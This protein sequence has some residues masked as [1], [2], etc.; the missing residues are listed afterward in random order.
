MGAFIAR[1][2][3]GLLCRWSSVVDNLTHYNMTEEDYV[4][5][6]AERAREEA[7]HNLQNPHFVKPFQEILDNRD[8][9]LI[10][11]ELGVIENQEEYTPE[12]V[13]KAKSEIKRLQEEFDGN[14]KM[15]SEPV[16]KHSVKYRNKQIVIEAIQWTGKNSVEVLMFAG[17]NKR[18]IGDVYENCPLIVHTIEGDMAANI[19]DYIVK[20]VNG[21]FYPYKSNIFEK[22]YEKA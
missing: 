11:Q 15:M 7:R 13:D 14:V 8:K 10:F 9:D 20:G 18:N 17:F 3:N 1:Q 16:M 5:Y 12:E 6:C 4:E 19:G 21:D 2:P 22:I